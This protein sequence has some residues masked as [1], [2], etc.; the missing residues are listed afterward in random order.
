VTPNNCICEQN[1]GVSPEAYR[2]CPW[3]KVILNDITQYSLNGA[4]VA[5]VNNFPFLQWGNQFTN[6]EGAFVNQLNGY[7]KVNGVKVGASLTVEISNQVIQ[8]CITIGDSC[9]G[10]WPNLGNN[11][12]TITYAILTKE[13]FVRYDSDTLDWL[14]KLLI[15]SSDSNGYHT[16]IHLTSSAVSE[17][18]QP[19]WIAIESV[20]PA[21]VYSVTF[22][23]NNAGSDGTFQHC[24]SIQLIGGESYFDEDDSALVADDSYN[25]AGS[26][27]AS[28]FLILSLLF[29]F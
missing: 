13:N 14:K 23:S 8:S 24:N 1:T 3:H 15:F 6:I 10:N 5:S 12:L 4:P 28:F 26:V 27:Y 21:F 16:E 20:W 17:N 19:I 2:T 11:N 7:F 9:S 29:L 22:N 25:S 18:G